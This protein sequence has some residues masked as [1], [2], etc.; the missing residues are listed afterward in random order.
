MSPALSALR[1]WLSEQRLDA[2]IL[3]RGD[4]YLGE[5]VATHDEMLAWLT[6]FT[7]SAGFAVV[8]QSAAYLYTDGRYQ[9]QGAAELKNSGFELRHS[10]R[11]K[12]DE[13]LTAAQ[14]S[15][16]NGFDP[17]LHSI[18]WQASAEKKLTA[19]NWKLIPAANPADALWQN[20]PAPPTGLA[21]IHALK[22]AGESGGAKCERLGKKLAA[23]NAAAEL[24]NDPTLTAWLLNL[25]GSDLPHTPIVQARAILH[26]SG[27]AELF[28]APEKISATVRAEL[29]DHVTVRAPETLPDAI[30]ALR[31][32]TL[33]LPAAQTPYALLQIAETAGA[34]M[35]TGPSVIVPARAIKNA[36]EQDGARTAHARD[37]AALKDF[38]AELPALIQ[39][40]TTEFEIA[41]RLAQHRTQQA[42]YAGESFPA[43]VGWNGNG[44]I[45]HY[46]PPERSSAAIIGNGILLIDSG[47][48]YRPGTTDVTRTVAVGA[49]TARQ[50]DV[51]TR[52]LKG[53]L[54]I[55]R[56]QFPVG[57]TGGQLDAL[58]RQF[59]WEAGFDY[60]HGT[61]HGVGSFLNVHEGPQRI[62]NRPD[63][64]A[65]APSM[66]LSN[67]PGCYLPGEFGV[68]IE[69]LVMVVP[70]A[71]KNL[72]K[73][74]GA[75]FLCFETLTLAPYDTALID[76]TLLTPT[77]AAQ[78]AAYDARCE[79]NS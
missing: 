36:T 68:R 4:A 38:F 62:T 46:R 55:A 42:D 5:Y 1:A 39:T 70:A 75:E 53:H 77:E 14:N 20:R 65:L 30:A 59:L 2:F 79:N 11:D 72:G 27:S 29:G 41:A 67:E 21:E 12:W 58:A 15:G 7:G 78:I 34:E 56:A 48:Q 22:F 60:D 47:G 40:G 50:R 32:K 43:I 6:G 18:E 57:T 54:A 33:R 71:Q 69:N 9:T 37:G 3:P 51:Y 19:Q 35:D 31:G 45:V 16:A 8:T 52:V 64:T 74:F 66:I 73:N 24:V 25:R 13:E 63:A 44:A 23:Q 10:G 61:G 28:I 49:P 26:A 76:P 17:W